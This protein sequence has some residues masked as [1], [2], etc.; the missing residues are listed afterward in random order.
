MKKKDL[1]PQK[2]VKSFPDSYG[3]E[4]CECPRCQFYI[5]NINKKGD[6]IQLNGVIHAECPNCKVKFDVMIGF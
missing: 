3:I 6:S 5:P 1:V 2:P 4:C